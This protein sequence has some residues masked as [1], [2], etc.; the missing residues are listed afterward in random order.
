MWVRPLSVCVCE[1]CNKF[2]SLYLRIVT[3]ITIGSG[4]PCCAA[5]ALHSNKFRTEREC[6]YYYLLL[7]PGRHFVG[8]AAAAA[9]ADMHVHVRG[10]SIGGSQARVIFNWKATQRAGNTHTIATQTRQHVQHATCHMPLAACLPHWR[11]LPLRV[12]RFNGDAYLQSVAHFAALECI[13][14]AT[15]CCTS[16]HSLCG[17]CSCQLA[18]EG[19]PT[20]TATVAT[21]NLL[22]CCSSCWAIIS[23]ACVQCDKYAV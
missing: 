19:C 13:L 8:Y 9:A 6:C 4:S 12:I 16:T 21:C 17:C 20:A 14:L 3:Q 2:A 7:P 23:S 18:A 10:G 11:A 5:Y 15:K 22:C 1:L